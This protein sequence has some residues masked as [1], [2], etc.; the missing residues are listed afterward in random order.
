MNQQVEISWQLTITFGVR[1]LFLYQTTTE[2]VDKF[3][4][5]SD[6]IIIRVIRI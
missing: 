1:E 5:Y 2:M 3:I 6:N 4:R